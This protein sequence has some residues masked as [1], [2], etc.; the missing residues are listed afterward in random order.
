MAPKARSRL[1]ILNKCL[2][3]PDRSLF[4]IT[5]KSLVRPLLE[6]NS[7]AIAPHLQKDIQNLKAVQ[8]TAT[9]QVRGLSNLSYPDRL[10]DLDLFP[11]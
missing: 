1:G 10:S 4:H 6:V 9:K 2:G 7:Q 8:R 11:L 5:F 3:R